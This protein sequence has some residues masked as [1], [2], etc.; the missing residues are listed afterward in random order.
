MSWLNSERHFGS[1]TSN[2]LKDCDGFQALSIGFPA[3]DAWISL[4]SRGATGFRTYPGVRDSV[5]TISR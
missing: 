2:Q 4:S 3:E 5:P 1:T